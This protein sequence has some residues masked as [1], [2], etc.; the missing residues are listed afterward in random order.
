MLLH[1]NKT[2]ITLVHD[3]SIAAIIFPEI[4]FAWN[5]KYGL[6]KYIDIPNETIYKN[7]AKTRLYL[8]NLFGN[9][10]GVFFK[11]YPK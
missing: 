11:I 2:L 1:K 3:T 5:P 8:S 7:D 10:I 6:S 4:I 9:N